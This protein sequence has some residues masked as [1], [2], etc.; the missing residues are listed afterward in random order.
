MWAAV[1]LSSQPA[2]DQC[3]DLPLTSCLTMDQLLT[4]APFFLSVKWG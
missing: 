3:P 1:T 2:W 4:H